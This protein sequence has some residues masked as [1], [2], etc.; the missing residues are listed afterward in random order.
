MKREGGDEFRNG[1]RNGA[2][3]DMALSGEGGSVHGR[4]NFVGTSSRETY[5][6]AHRCSL[7]ISNSAPCAVSSPA[8]YPVTVPPL[9]IS[10]ILSTHLS[11]RMLGASLLP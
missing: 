5:R 6:P 3:S 11:Y 8:F 4:S 10:T 7:P 2:G 1:G 9:R